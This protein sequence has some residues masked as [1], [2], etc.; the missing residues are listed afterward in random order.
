MEQIHPD[1]T[2][3]GVACDNNE[4]ILVN[5][6]NGL[7]KAKWGIDMIW[8]K[9]LKN[10]IEILNELS[11]IRYQ[12]VKISAADVPLIIINVYLPTAGKDAF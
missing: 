1:Y 12:I 7:T 4:P 6:F 10:S 2:G 11:D 8:D 5:G 3:A 9:S